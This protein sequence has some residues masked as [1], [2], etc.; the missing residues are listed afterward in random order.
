[1]ATELFLKIYKIR[2]LGFEDYKKN[3]NIFSTYSNAMF[4]MSPGFA[5]KNGVSIFL[6]FK[7]LD[8]LGTDDHKDFHTRATQLV[9]IGCFALTE[10]TH[11][12]NVKGILTEAHYDH[13]T[14]EFIIHSPTRDAM[15]F[16]IGAAANVANIAVVW[17]QLYIDGK[18]H[19]V[20]VYLVPLRDNKTHNPLPGVTLGDCGPKNGLN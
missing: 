13:A 1:M 8:V 10:A 7:T 12:S 5:V 9:D 19:G 16:W 2:D 15:K 20:H 11:G 3:P 6:Y 18:C 4:A 17:A 14:Q